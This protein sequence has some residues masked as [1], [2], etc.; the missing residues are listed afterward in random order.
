MSV[1]AFKYS[2]GDFFD[3]P[4]GWG[5]CGQ[6]NSWMDFLPLLLR[7]TEAVQLGALLPSPETIG[8]IY[9]C[10]QFH[11]WE[12]FSSRQAEWESFGLG[13]FGLFFRDFLGLF[14]WDSSKTVVST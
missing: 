5:E 2:F 4:P 7:E 11:S 14:N 3:G 12:E 9:E 8:R 6:V 13:L 1:E 10:I